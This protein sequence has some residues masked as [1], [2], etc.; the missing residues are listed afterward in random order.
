MN[1]TSSYNKFFKFEVKKIPFP[2]HPECG[3]Q[4]KTLF[5]FF[6]NSFISSNSINSFNSYFYLG[7]INV[8]GKNENSSG[9]NKANL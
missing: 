5:Y 4:I 6:Y 1:L 2:W 8:K 7:K 3:L 9:K